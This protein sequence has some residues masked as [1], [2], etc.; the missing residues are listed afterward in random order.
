V[1]SN[2]EQL[3]YFDALAMLDVLSRCFFFF[4]FYKIQKLC[5]THKCRKCGF[6]FHNKAA[7][8]NA[9]SK[10]PDDQYDDEDFLIMLTVSRDW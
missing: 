7:L 2:S 5:Q 6:I 9:K 4:V 8:K 1:N 3:N 10:L